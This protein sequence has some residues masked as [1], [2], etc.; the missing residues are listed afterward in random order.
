[1]N[2]HTP[3]FIWVIDDSSKLPIFPDGITRYVRMD[4]YEEVLN[5]AI[6]NPI[7]PAL[8]EAAPEMLAALELI[9]D[10][11]GIRDDFAPLGVGVALGRP[12]LAA[13]A[14]AKGE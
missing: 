8:I 12:I 1:M 3:Q 6:E 13:I 9:R 5:S 14:K 7:R 11:L 4:L 10:E 2:K